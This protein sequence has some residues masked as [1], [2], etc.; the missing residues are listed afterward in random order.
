MSQSLQVAAGFCAVAVG[1]GFWAARTVPAPPP[2]RIPIPILDHAP[3]STWSPPPPLPQ[4]LPLEPT[5]PFHGG[6][7]WRP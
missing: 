7:G 5:G 2:A 6:A 3:A 4:V 1:F